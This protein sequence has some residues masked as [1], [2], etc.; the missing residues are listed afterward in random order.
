MSDLIPPTA[1][2][3]KRRGTGPIAS[4]PAPAPQVAPRSA[5][6]PAA[7]PPAEKILSIGRYEREDFE[8]VEALIAAMVNRN[9]Q[10]RGFA[11]QLA[12]GF[13]APASPQERP[14]RELQAAFYSFMMYG[15]RDSN[16]VRIVDLF[17][18][19]APQLTVRQQAALQACARARMVLVAID[20]VH[21]GKQRIRGRDLLRDEPLTMRDHNATKIARE[22]DRMLCWLIPWGTAW[23]P[24]GVATRVE[25]RKAEALERAIEAMANGLRAVRRELPERHA[26]DLFWVA[27][28]VANLD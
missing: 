8:R 18:N 16:G 10:I 7:Q 26:A 17:R 2:R 24:I 28:R 3:R 13:F 23:Q 22:G 20:D 21:P 15:W 25:A 19:S 27:Y 14:L 12:R 1:S 4:A 6:A 9:Q 11:E 5:S